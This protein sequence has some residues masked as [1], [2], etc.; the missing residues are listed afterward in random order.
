MTL[1]SS[2]NPWFV[3]LMY[4]LL[5]NEPH[6]LELL[7]G[8]ETNPGLYRRPTPPRY[9]RAKLYHY[10]FTSNFTAPDWWR[11]ELKQEYFPVMDLKEGGKSLRDFLGQQGVL[12]A[13]GSEVVDASK[14][15]ELAR[16]LD[17]VRA[18]LTRVPDHLLVQSLMWAG[19]PMLLALSP[20]LK[21]KLLW[22]LPGFGN[23]N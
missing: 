2:H 18:A 7:G 20:G 4:R 3:S 1:F 14:N 22:F 8:A 19:L 11:R 16:G 10:H 12:N 15:V 9:V 17:A 6:V 5:E 21:D 23:V 13:D